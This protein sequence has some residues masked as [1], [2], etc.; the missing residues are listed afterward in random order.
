[1]KPHTKRV[2]HHIDSWT[3]QPY[4]DHIYYGR[5]ITFHDYKPVPRG[6]P[7][8]P[9]EWMDM[10]ANTAWYSGLNPIFFWDKPKKALLD[11][12]KINGRLVMGTLETRDRRRK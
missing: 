2:R 8:T 9:D 12:W 1:M 5:D 10:I 3:K 4:T 7:F 6:S 11:N